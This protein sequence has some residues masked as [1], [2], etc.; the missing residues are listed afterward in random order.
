MQPIYEYFKTIGATLIKGVPDDEQL[1]LIIQS[2]EAKLIILD[3]MMEMLDSVMLSKIFTVHVHHNNLSCI[4]L[5]QNLFQ[6]SKHLRTISLNTQY[7]MVFKSP[8]DTMQ[9]KTLGRQM[10]GS[11]QFLEA[12][13]HD[14]TKEP[15]GHLLIDFRQNTPEN[16]RV[17]SNV[18]NAF[19][20]VYTAS[21]KKYKSSVLRGF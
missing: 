6:K 10:H 4:F 11:G 21:S 12:A 13:F 14:C 7:I 8:R 9:I 5:T 16:I 2:P 17:R 3:D 1:H 19:P 20:T 18:F 15:Y